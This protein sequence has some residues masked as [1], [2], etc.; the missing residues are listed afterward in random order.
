M[1]F[2]LSGMPKKIFTEVFTLFF[3]FHISHSEYSL[4]N[5]NKVANII[6]LNVIIDYFPY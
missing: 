1:E 3:F 6:F 4:T 5:A 2:I